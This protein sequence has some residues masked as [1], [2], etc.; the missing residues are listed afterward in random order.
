[1]HYIV[2]S[3]KKLRDQGLRGHTKNAWDGSFGNVKKKF[4]VAP[5]HCPA[6]IHALI[7]SCAKNTT[8]ICQA[9]NFFWEFQFTVRKIQNEQVTQLFVFCKKLGTVTAKS[10]T[11]SNDSETFYLL[12]LT[13]TLN[14]V[15]KRTYEA[16]DSSEY[17]KQWP[18][19][20]TVSSAKENNRKAYSMKFLC[21]KYIP[22]DENFVSEYF[23]SSAGT[24]DR[25]IFMKI[26]SL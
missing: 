1:M 11:T 25:E 8:I 13:R 17:I 6:E 15:K 12:K 10:F 2:T 23:S 4:D 3:G 14:V 19:L 22:G 18:S 21:H 9:W 24:L 7:N 5:V 20:G 26:N 16:L